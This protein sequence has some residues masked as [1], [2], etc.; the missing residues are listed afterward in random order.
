[1][2]LFLHQ[3][4]VTPQSVVCVLLK[5]QVRCRPIPRYL[6]GLTFHAVLLRNRCPL[7]SLTLVPGAGETLPE[8]SVRLTQAKHECI[9]PPHLPRVEHQRTPSLCFAMLSLPT[10]QFQAQRNNLSRQNIGL[11]RNKQFNNF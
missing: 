3:S 5:P 4:I 2:F 10:C 7:L 9:S 6:V 11:F 1:M 8:R